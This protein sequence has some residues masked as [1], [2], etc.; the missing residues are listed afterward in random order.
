[1]VRMPVDS[2]MPVLR[3]K[4]VRAGTNQSRKENLPGVHMC[5]AADHTLAQPLPRHVTEKRVGGRVPKK[6]ENCSDL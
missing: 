2:L 5:S 4:K 6:D 3:A 1:M